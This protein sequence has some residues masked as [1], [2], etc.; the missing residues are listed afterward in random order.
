MHFNLLLIECSAYLLVDLMNKLY[1]SPSLCLILGLGLTK[2]GREGQDHRQ[3]SVHAS[4][5]SN[6]APHSLLLSPLCVSGAVGRNQCHVTQQPLAS[7]I[8]Q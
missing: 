3:S 6:T 4:H 8:S 5:V 1:F 7:Y 2:S